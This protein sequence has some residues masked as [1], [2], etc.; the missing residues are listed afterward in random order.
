MN[1]S[2]SICVLVFQTKLYNNYWCILYPGRG[3]FAPRLDL[4]EEK[5]QVGQTPCKKTIYLEE[6]KWVKTDSLDPAF[7]FVVKHG[8][9]YILV[10]A[11]KSGVS[12]WILFLCCVSRDLFDSKHIIGIEDLDK[13]DDY[14]T[15]SGE[16]YVVKENILYCSSSERK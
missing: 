16:E 13:M 10:P 7:S 2:Q 5:T 1:I 14:Q 15:E 4:Y 3:T 12:L 11:C 8:K 6:A 9:Q